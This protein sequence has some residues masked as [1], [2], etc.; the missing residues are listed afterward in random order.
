MPAIILF[1]RRT[2]I[3]GDDLQPGAVVTIIVRSVLQL[4]L[5]IVP[6]LFGIFQIIFTYGW[7]QF[8]HLSNNNSD[9]TCTKEGYQTYPVWL[10]SYELISALYCLLSVGL[11]T[12]ICQI[13][14]EGTPSEPK[15]RSQKVTKLLEFRLTLMTILNLF[16]FCVGLYATHAA[17]WYYK[18]KAINGTGGAGGNLVHNADEYIPWD[19]ID[20]TWITSDQNLKDGDLN[21]LNTSFPSSWRL[22]LIFLLGSQAI[23]VVSGFLGICALWS[24]PRASSAQALSSRSGFTNAEAGQSGANLSFSSSSEHLHQ[25]SYYGPMEEM[26]QNRCRLCC[27]FSGMATCYIFGGRDL[28]TTGD[29]T[30]IAT[31]LTDYF[32]DGGAL[33]IVPSDV[34]MGFMLLWRIQTQRQT[35]ARRSLLSKISDR[36]NSLLQTS[37]NGQA[38]PSE[39]LVID[40]RY[41]EALNLVSTSSELSLASPNYMLNTAS[42]TEG[43]LRLNPISEHATDLPQESP[44]V[45]SPSHTPSGIR[46]EALV[47]ITRRD[48][49][50][51]FY[52]CGFRDVLMENNGFDR[53]VM[54][55]AAR[56]ARH[57]LAIYS[58]KLYAYMY[59]EKVVCTLMKWRCQR[60]VGACEGNNHK[61]P[62]IGDNSWHVHENAVLK[63]VGLHDKGSSPPCE[64]VY[65]RFDNGLRETPYCVLLDH[66]WKSIV[67]SIRGSLSLED[68]VIDVLCDPEPL[69]NVGRRFGFDAN[70]EFCHSGVLSRTEWLFQDLAR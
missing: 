37:L 48:G 59:P 40:L 17:R 15:N 31:V 30:Q 16:V 52:D 27:K 60:F 62:Y 54:A 63:H 25:A 29:F 32:E 38:Q 14:S 56:F 69:E 64:L 58:W 39:E 11:E 47:Y 43:E 46:H 10:L 19:V 65:A 55:E 18:C 26:W 35:E 2:M 23:E 66:A 67:I 1:G 49:S 7:S 24:L 42:R 20:D 68:C 6:V 21:P 44:L 50:Q 41:A 45:F 3:G 12:A 36:S 70:G 9:S 28:H 22:W 34:V 51:Q 53:K 33:D 5:F 4:A 57:S 8:S 61:D 13:S